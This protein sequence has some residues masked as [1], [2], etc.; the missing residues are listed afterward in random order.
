MIPKLPNNAIDYIKSIEI[1]TNN[2][3]DFTI[4]DHLN[5]K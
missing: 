1:L 3:T 4:F 2:L 5:Y